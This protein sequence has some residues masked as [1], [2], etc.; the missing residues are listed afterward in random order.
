MNRFTILSDGNV[1]IGTIAPATRLDIADN[2]GHILL[3]DAG[4]NAGFTGLGFGS[5]LSSCLN[6]SL[7]GNGADT[8]IGRP[9]G[10]TISFREANLAQMSILSGGKVG[11]G[12]AA[13]VTALHVA[14]SI[15]DFTFSPQSFNH[16]ATIENTST[17]DSAVSVLALKVGFTGTVG[18]GINYVTFLRTGNA[19]TGD[20]PVGAIEGNGFGGVS[21]NSG[22]ADYAELLPRLNSAEHIQPGEIVGLFDGRVTKRTRGATQVM[23]VSTGPVVLGN[24][25][26]KDTRGGYEKV[27]FIGQVMARVRGTVQ[28]G[29][30]IIASGLDDGTG[31][32]V[33]PERITSEQFKQAVGQAWEKSVDSGVKSVR[34]AVGLIQRDPTVSRLLESNRDQSARIAAME[35]RLNAFEARMQSKATARKLAAIRKRDGQ[36]PR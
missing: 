22:G 4:C 11:I 20:L 3:G 14:R 8:I 6:Y 35:A 30:F 32:A 33:S 2:S 36:T 28:A 9:T 18:N 16:V 10:G 24:D 12:T 1:G 26:G 25:P 5:S 27:A 19:Q 17:G 23:A 29:D 21:Y 15:Q 13:P 34:I 7:L 31:V